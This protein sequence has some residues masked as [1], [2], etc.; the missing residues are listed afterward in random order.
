M[1]K[2]IKAFL[3]ASDLGGQGGVEGRGA[4]HY[5]GSSSSASYSSSSSSF[6]SGGGASAEFE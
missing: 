6:S 4:Q 3:A 2:V 5:G 1:S